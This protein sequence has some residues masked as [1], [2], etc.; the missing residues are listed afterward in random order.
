[1]IINAFE[2]RAINLGPLALPKRGSDPCGHRCGRRSGLEVDTNRWRSLQVP[3]ECH[4]KTE[5]IAVRATE[6]AHAGPTT[7]PKG[8]DLK[9]V[10]IKPL[11]IS[12]QLLERA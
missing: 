3:V 4:P 1:M 11:N 7:V 10:C 2:S 6:E 8:S 9:P 5:C 12:H